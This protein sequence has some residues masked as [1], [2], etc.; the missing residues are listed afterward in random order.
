MSQSGIGYK[1][2][3]PCVEPDLEYKSMYCHG[4]YELGHTYDDLKHT[5]LETGDQKYKTGYHIYRSLAAVRRHYEAYLLSWVVVKV[6][7]SNVVAEGTQRKIYRPPSGRHQRYAYY[8]TIVARR[9]TLL[10]EIEI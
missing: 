7:Y 4:Y 10:E 1:V 9:M 8:K 6:S 5:I 2:F 3:R